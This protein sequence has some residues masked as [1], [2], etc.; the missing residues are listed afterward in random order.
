M[1]ALKNIKVDDA[2]PFKV[3]AQYKSSWNEHEE[4]ADKADEKRRPKKPK[5]PKKS[6][7]LKSASSA[8]SALAAAESSK[9]K[10]YGQYTPHVY[11]QQ[12]TQYIEARRAE[13]ASYAL[14]NA[15]WNLSKEK[16]QL[17]RGANFRANSEKVFGQG[18]PE[19]PMV[20][21]IRR[22]WLFTLHL[23]DCAHG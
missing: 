18:C 9:Q 2:A 15:G 10:R 5:K 16:A 4:A 17:V 7:V 3:S 12:R 20:K 21:L 8:A 1:S 14:A 13:G 19:Q 6:K 23:C 11:K 22:Q